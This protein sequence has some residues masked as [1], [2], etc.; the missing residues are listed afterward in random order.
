MTQYVELEEIL[1]LHVWYAL[2]GWIL[3]LANRRHHNLTCGFL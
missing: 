3:Y 1:H 2:F